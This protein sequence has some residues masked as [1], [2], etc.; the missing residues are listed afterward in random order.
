M[1]RPIA[2]LDLDCT[3]TDGNLLLF[4][5]ATPLRR[6]AGWFYTLQRVFAELLLSLMLLEKKYARGSRRIGPWPSL[7]VGAVADAT[8]AVGHACMMLS[9]SVL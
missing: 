5:Q 6:L 9:V 3:R 2:T 8:R 7:G 4:L 1:K